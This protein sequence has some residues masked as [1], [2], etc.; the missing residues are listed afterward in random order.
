VTADEQ[1]AQRW[2]D[3]DH[4]LYEQARLRP[5]FPGWVS[6]CWCCCE[7]CDPDF[8]PARPNPYWAQAQ[9]QQRAALLARI[10]GSKR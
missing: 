7:M 2:H 6:G 5:D 8:E 4:G 9:V 1:Q 3:T 10:E